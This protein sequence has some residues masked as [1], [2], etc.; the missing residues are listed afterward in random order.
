M[1]FWRMQ[2]HP[3]APGHAVAHAI[4]S[5]SSGYIGLD[6]AGDVGDLL[7]GNQSDLLPGQKDYWAFAHEMVIG[8]LVLI[9]VHHFPFALA[10]VAGPYNYIRNVV[11]ELGVWFRHFREVKEVSYY[12]DFKTNARDWEKTIMTDTISPLRDPQTISFRLIS[13]WSRSMP[14]PG[15]AD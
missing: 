3:A 8:D 11:P 14:G 9:V 4:S 7:R 1:S 15:S 13:E 6:F 2:M 5:L 10:R 12:A